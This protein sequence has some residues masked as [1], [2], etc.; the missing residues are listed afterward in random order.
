MKRSSAKL[1]NK[2]IKEDARM[3][4]RERKKREDRNKTTLIIKWRIYLVVVETV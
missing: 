2:S 4:E 1:S 3:R